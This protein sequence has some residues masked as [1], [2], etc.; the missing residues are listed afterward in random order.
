MLSLSRLKV[1][2]YNI[3]LGEGVDEEQPTLIL[4]FL[5]PSDPEPQYYVEE[6]A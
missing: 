2:L 4:N 6:P 3:L 1:S 5:Q